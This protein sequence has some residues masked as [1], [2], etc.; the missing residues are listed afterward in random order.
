MTNLPAYPVECN[1]CRYD[2]GVFGVM[3]TPVA[4]ES[5]GNDWVNIQYHCPRCLGN[6][7]ALFPCSLSD[8]N[9]MVNA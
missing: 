1:D 5:Q 8:L 6:D 2:D 3:M 4:I 9:G 7:Y